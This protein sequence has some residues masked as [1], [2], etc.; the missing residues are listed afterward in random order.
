LLSE[1]Q[2]FWAKLQC[3]FKKGAF[4]DTP[5]ATVSRRPAFAQLRA[6]DKAGLRRVRF[7]VCPLSAPELLGPEQIRTYQP[8]LV[9][10]KKV[11]VS[12]FNHTV[13]ALHSFTARRW[14][15]TVVKAGSS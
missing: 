12:R 8:Y 10:E 6:Q 15:K 2:W 7:A 3:R 11:S 13:C 1:G 14:A 9:H 5:S 4:D